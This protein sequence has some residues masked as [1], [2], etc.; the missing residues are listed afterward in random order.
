MSLNGTVNTIRTRNKNPSE[1]FKTCPTLV[2]CFEIL[3]FQRT[4]Y[5]TGRVLGAQNKLFEEKVHAF[6]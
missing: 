3:C 2:Y 6:H 1:H 5:V 4:L